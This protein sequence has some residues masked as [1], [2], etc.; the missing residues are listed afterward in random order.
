MVKKFYITTPIFYV[1]DLLHIGHAYC[2]IACDVVAR[3]KRWVGNEVLFL[4]GTD[5]HGQ[6]IAQAAS[7][8]GKTP[9]EWADYIVSE[10]KKL[11]EKLNISHDD[12]IRTT[13]ARHERTVRAIFTK[14][15][16]KG[17]IYKGEYEGWYCTSCE[18]FYLESQLDEGKCPECGKVAEKLKEES[19][20]FRLSKYQKRLLNY[21][22]KNPEFMQPSFRKA[23]MVNFVKEGLKDLSVSRTAVEWGIPVPFDKKHTVYVWFDALINYLTACGYL[24]DKVKFGKFWPADV[25]L[26][27]KEI[28]KFHTIIWPAMLM[29][30][31]IPLPK[32]VFG[33]GWW[34]VEGEK[35][36][37]SRG[38]VVDPVEVSEEFGV[39]AFRYFLMREVPFGQD[40]DFSKKALIRRYNADLANNLGNLL[41]R[42]L[43]MVEKYLDGRVSEPGVEGEE[44]RE[45]IQKVKVLFER[46][47]KYYDKLELNSVLGDIWEV[48]E[49]ANRY[50][51]KTA[52][53]KLEKTDRKRLETV[54]YNILETLR[55]VALYILPFMPETAERIWERLGMEG[56]IYNQKIEEAEWGRLKPGTKI[57]T[58]KPLFPRINADL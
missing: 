34:T 36:S 7:L 45:L 53:W 10:D 26:V 48:I 17:D 58:G 50:I 13:E 44:D 18:T 21:F 41:S 22:E 27:G 32:K 14:L 4:T 51:E 2:T 40:G 16:Q 5:E 24:D 49:Y 9:L 8:K 57:K 54:L 19:Y 6:K 47:V 25:H 56:K 35:M 46:V 39:D 15:Y 37:K 31:E 11:W 28:F 30:L 20:F 3:F 12:F 52:P 33:H 1:N 38:N 42:S 29:A 55:V 23:E 43:T